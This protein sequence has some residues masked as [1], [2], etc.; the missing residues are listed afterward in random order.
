MRNSPSS[1]PAASV[2]CCPAEVAGLRSVFEARADIYSQFRMSRRQ[3]AASLV[4]SLG[5]LAGCGASREV[6]EE[7]RVFDVVGTIPGGWAGARA[8][9]YFGLLSGHDVNVDLLFCDSFASAD[10]LAAFVDRL[11]AD[12]NP[13]RGLVF[14]FDSMAADESQ[15]TYSAFTS[16]QSQ[17]VTLSI[18]E[19]E[20]CVD[21]VEV[22]GPIRQEL[23]DPSA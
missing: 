6:E 4:V 22:Q 5:L 13:A 17:V 19:S 7:P 2:S 12:A 23:F 21:K 3:I 9:L 8:G 10:Q 11:S 18:S 14:R 15:I 16:G 20:R 1:S